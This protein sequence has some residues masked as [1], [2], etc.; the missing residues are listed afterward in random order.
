VISTR[1]SNNNQP[2]L[3]GE[4]EEQKSIENSFVKLDDVEEERIARNEGQALK[5]VAKGKTLL[6]FGK[7]LVVWIKFGYFLVKIF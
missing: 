4:D 3:E 6:V 7:F 5:E 1:Q 2:P